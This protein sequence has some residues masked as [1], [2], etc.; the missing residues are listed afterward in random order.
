MER[1]I[2]VDTLREFS[3]IVPSECSISVLKGKYRSS[4]QYNFIH[5]LD[6]LTFFS[7]E[8]PVMF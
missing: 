5:F 8:N 2:S 4:T 1:R 6:N 3:K 7:L